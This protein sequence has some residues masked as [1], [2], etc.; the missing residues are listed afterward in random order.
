M[1]SK[2]IEHD[3]SRVKFVHTL[4]RLCHR[5]ETRRLKASKRKKLEFVVFENHRASSP[6]KRKRIVDGFQNSLVGEAV[7]E[8]PDS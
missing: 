3:K 4:A 7:K 5:Q 8:E 1:L 6:R 2:P